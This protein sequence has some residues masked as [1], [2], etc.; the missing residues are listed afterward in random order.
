MGLD[1]IRRTTPSFDRVL[2]RRAIELRTPRLFNRDMPLVARTVC[3]ELLG[4]TNVTKGERVILRVMNEKVVVQRNNVIVAECLNPP[5]DFV[6]RLNEGA[7]IARGEIK[8]LQ[9]ISRTVEVG[10]CE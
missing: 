5:G 8:S 2:D 7:G 4:D 6:S 1:F 10:F 9:P 3:A